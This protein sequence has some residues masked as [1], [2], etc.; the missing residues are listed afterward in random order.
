MFAGEDVRRGGGE[1]YGELHERLQTA[2][3]TILPA[4]QAR[5]S[6]WSATA[7]RCAAW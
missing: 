5:P 7:P 2:I 4:I 6:W 1:T 3:D